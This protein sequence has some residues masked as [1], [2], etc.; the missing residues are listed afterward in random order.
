MTRI[1]GWGCFFLVSLRLLIGWH[2]LVEG[3]HKVHTHRVGRTT[4]NT[5][6][7]GEG[8][9]REGIGPLGSYY[10]EALGIDDKPA[11]AK[12][13][14][15][16]KVLPKALS[17]EWDTYSVR[18]AD[19][20][21]LDEAQKAAAIAKLSDAKIK[22]TAWLTGEFP[23][24]VKKVV[25]WG[26]ADVK[27][28]VPQRLAEY[29]AKAK[30]IEDAYGSKLPAFNADVEKTRLR[31]AKADAARI[32]N[33]LIADL[34]SQTT[35][36]QSA[37]ATVLT[38]DQAKDRGPVPDDKPMRAIDILDKVTMWTHV[39]LGACLL[40]GLFSRFASFLLA[41]FLLQIV[42]IAPPLPFAPTPPGA[43]GH[44]LYINLYT[45]EMVALLALASIPTGRWFG[46]DALLDYFSHRKTVRA[47]SASN[48]RRVSN[49]EYPAPRA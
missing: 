42:L 30:E 22:T 11:L 3:V 40:L 38:A 33:D 7:S 26:T 49:F 34:D 16:G 1:N 15:D 5:P 6:W 21:K 13:R 8:F 25:I 28:T 43:V 41:G 48:R 36:M 9:F 14:A 47:E 46:V 4:T 19:H 20:Y 29:D 10:R 18:F 32:L 37:L 45:I 31:T 12:L 44:Y 24:D 2:F 17:D 39:A 35:S 23:T 27:Q